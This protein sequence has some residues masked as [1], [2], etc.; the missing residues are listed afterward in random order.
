VD[1]VLIQCT[2]SYIIGGVV[3]LIGDLLQGTLFGTSVKC[4][5]ILT[6]WRTLTSAVRPPQQVALIS[7]GTFIFKFLNCP[8][9]SI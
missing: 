1:F 8:W 4:G 6:H 3:Q 2:L 9:V 7:F 5:C